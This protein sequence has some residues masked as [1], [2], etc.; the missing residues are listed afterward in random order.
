MM[1]YQEPS[2]EH[3]FIYG[4]NLE[5][6][7][8][9]DH[10][11]R[12]VKGLIDFDFIYKEVK[13]TYGTKGNVSV[14][15]PV[16]L[17]LMLLLILYNVRSERELME[18][19][20]ERMDWLWFLGYTLTSSVPDHS[21]LSKAR[22]RWGEEAFKH[23]FEGI[24][25]QCVEAGLVDGKKIFM[26]ASLIDADAS[27]NSVVDTYSLTRHLNARYRELEKR[28]DE[29]TKTP[30]EETTQKCTECAP[31][32]ETGNTTQETTDQQGPS[33]DNTV[34]S[35]YVSTT[36]PD[37]SIVRQGKGKPELQYK[38]HRA[39]E[40]RHEVITT[41]KVT[42]GAVNEGHEMTALIEGHEAN[43][44]IKVTTVIA[45]SQYGTKENLLACHD[46]EIQPHMPVVKILNAETGSR[47][48]IF[49]EERFTY[50]KETDTYTC[51][52][53]KILKKRTLHENKQNI[54]YAASK[55]DC[56]A[57]A[58][59]SECTKSKG[60]RTVQRHVRQDELDRMITIARSY[61]AR[62]DLKTRQHLMERSYARSTRYGFDRARWRGLWKVAIQEYLV[63]AIQNIQVLLR[64]GK[65]PA[66][67]AFSLTSVRALLNLLY[68][69]CNLCRWLYRCAILKV[70]GSLWTH[71]IPGGYWHALAYRSEGLGNRPSRADPA[72]VP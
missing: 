31:S 12:K 63:A 22:K 19:L 56:A 14:P 27:N 5:S 32:G 60:P 30:S 39:V 37:A 66:Q 51:P 35:R 57:C 53:G 45:D 1:G 64:Y 20:P 18:T 9:K 52:A 21:V 61:Q 6:R 49:P 23:F 59:R 26:D 29:Q 17:K 28:L 55:R 47:N 13:K 44:S 67:G 71:G 46:R 58:L 2:H 15:P 41:V 24:V 33:G 42:P 65:E 7:V 11:L 16:I 70:T 36:D 43:T 48:G 4:I 10:P 69:L 50:D 34:N 40:G 3:L 54:E 38:T 25:T 68:W 8:R 62:S 72:A